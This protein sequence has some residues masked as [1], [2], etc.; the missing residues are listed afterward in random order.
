[1][2]ISE[3][4]AILFVVDG[5]GG[6]TVEDIAFADKVRRMEKEV[7]LLVNKSEAGDRRTKADKN[8]LYKLG[9]GDPIYIS[10]M[11]G[12]GSPAA[13]GRVAAGRRSRA[14][15]AR[16]AIAADRAR[17]DGSPRT[18]ASG[19]AARRQEPAAPRADHRRWS[20][21]RRG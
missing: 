21:S 5:L 18:S 3:A 17:T 4:N 14:C 20:R 16:C 8:D 10:A 11:H 15:N 7:I 6:I 9:L 12:T 2:A 1:M 13:H 19:P